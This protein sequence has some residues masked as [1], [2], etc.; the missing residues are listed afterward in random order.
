MGDQSAVQYYFQKN[1]RVILMHHVAYKDSAYVQTLSDDDMQSL[2]MTD[3]Q[4]EFGSR[5]V[6]DLNEI[7][8]R[9]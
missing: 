5:Y 8:K 3:E 6:V 7:N 4:K 9:R 2:G 1:R